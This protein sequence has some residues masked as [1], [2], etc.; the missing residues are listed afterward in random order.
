MGFFG[1]IWGGIKSAG[2]AVLG[3]IESAGETVAHGVGNVL[4]GKNPFS[5]FS[6]QA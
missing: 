4:Q 3:G 6:S 2:S 1:D 5:N